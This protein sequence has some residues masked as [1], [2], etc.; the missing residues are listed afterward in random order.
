MIVHKSHNCLKC[1]HMKDCK[2]LPEGCTNF[3][4]A[5]PIQDT[6][7]ALSELAERLG[8]VVLTKFSPDPEGDIDA[9]RKAKRIIEGLAKVAYS[10]GLSYN[11]VNAVVLSRA[12]AEDKEN[13]RKQ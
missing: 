11:A 4:M 12:I 2:S 8:Q 10:D 5:N 7:N 9:V 6:R 3:E 1:K 13:G